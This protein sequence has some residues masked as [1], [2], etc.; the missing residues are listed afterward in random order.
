MASARRHPLVR[1]GASLLLATVVIAAGACNS[2]SER[3][4]SSST[5]GQPVTTSPAP[6]EKGGAPVENPAP[7][8][9]VETFDGDT[10]ALGEQLGT[11]VVLNF[12]E[13]W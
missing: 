8:F 12:W 11:P 9:T 6:R 5:T 3:P 4:A 13:S 1:P 7:E 10:F 2:D